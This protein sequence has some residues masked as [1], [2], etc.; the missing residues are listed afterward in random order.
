V[1]I[2]IAAGSMVVGIVVLI[3]SLLVL[4]SYVSPHQPIPELQLDESLPIATDTDV[5]LRGSKALADGV[6]GELDGV[7]ILDARLGSHVAESESFDYRLPVPLGLHHLRIWTGPSKD[8]PPTELAD[9][10]VVRQSE[11]PPSPVLLQASE[12]RLGDSFS[13]LVGV[14]PLARVELRGASLAGQQPTPGQWVTAGPAPL[15]GRLSLTLALDD[16]AKPIVEIRETNSAGAKSQPTSIT[17]GEEIQPPVND[18]TEPYA[19]DERVT[20][21]VSPT[22][23]VQT[24][25]VRLPATRREVADFLADRAIAEEPRNR[26]LPAGR[27]LMQ[28]IA[29]PVDLELSST[30]HCFPSYTEFDAHATVALDAGKATVTMVETDG[31]LR[32]TFGLDAR[33]VISLCSQDGFPR[34]GSRGSI[35]I[36]VVGYTVL[37]TDPAPDALEHRGR[38]SD[39]T[40]LTWNHL[41]PNQVVRVYVARPL[42]QVVATIL[43]PYPLQGWRTVRP[44]AALVVVLPWLIAVLVALRAVSH[45]RNTVPLRESFLALGGLAVGLFAWPAMAVVSTSLVVALQPFSDANLPDFAAVAIAAGFGTG[46]VIVAVRGTRREGWIRRAI[47]LS[48][49]VTAVALGIGLLLAPRP[50]DFSTSQANRTLDW[51]Y[52]ILAAGVTF[53]VMLIVVNQVPR[54]LRP[55][56][57]KLPFGV[58]IAL[59]GLSLAAFVPTGTIADY[60]HAT[61]IDQYLYNIEGVALRLQNVG[62][63]LLFLICFAVA[64]E[65]AA[66]DRTRTDLSPDGARQWIDRLGALLFAL[67]AV[68][69]GGLVFGFPASIL[70]AAG[71]FGFVLLSPAATRPALDRDRDTIRSGR[72]ELLDRALGADQLGPGAPT[73]P[74]A[75]PSGRAARDVVLSV[76]PGDTSFNVRLGMIVALGPTAVLLLLY[77][78]QL[79]A[80]TRASPFAWLETGTRLLGFTARWLVIGG[81]FG[82]LYERIRGTTGIRKSL[83][84]GLVVLAATVPFDLARAIADGTSLGAIVVDVVQ[85]LAFTSIIGIGFDLATLRANGLG[86]LGHPRETASTLA[87]L[88]G[89]A[90]AL[91]AATTMVS[92]LVG[93]IGASLTGSLKDVVGQV[94]SGIAPIVTRGVAGG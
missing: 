8:A 53:V 7:P 71:L 12:V 78:L 80:E 72:A 39:D 83:V 89:A 68:G 37:G 59:A 9:G 69:A 48:I 11:T 81:L 57:I 5:K 70:V 25:V 21:L 94:I 4:Y 22:D 54:V 10:W 30:N 76:G 44:I 52:L 2:A 14:E 29:V 51:I 46:A 60:L 74:V 16:R 24:T 33:P 85:V 55:N 58:V 62:E 26:Q 23:V 75:I 88:S 61:S 32:E 42:S 67:F 63:L 65:L 86:S 43:S 82:L 15:D 73:R 40:T 93:V 47:L 66:G 91:P 13:L 41:R 79:A 64:L 45:L 3:A 28:A 27:Q 36:D 38:S 6:F 34:R 56:G 31:R 50:D 18:R 77:V 49:V 87:S 19:V 17:V 90:F 35:A 92:A 1:S 20:F 84:F